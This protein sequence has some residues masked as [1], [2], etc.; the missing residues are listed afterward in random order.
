MLF[1]LNCIHHFLSFGFPNNVRSNPKIPNVVSAASNNISLY[2]VL[3]YSK[4]ELL[5]EGSTDVTQFS[6]L[7][8]CRAIG[9]SN[10]SILKVYDYRGFNYISSYCVSNYE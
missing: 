2:L 10:S 5:H 6:A 1:L 3:S 7:F 4:P 9:T 8:N